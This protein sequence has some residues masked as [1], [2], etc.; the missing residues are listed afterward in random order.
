MASGMISARPQLSAVTCVD[1]ADSV[2]DVSHGEC[3]ASHLKWRRAHAD[4]EPKRRYGARRPAEPEAEG[5]AL[6][7][8]ADRRM[9]GIIPRP[10][11]GSPASRRTD[12]IRDHRCRG[13]QVHRYASVGLPRTTYGA[14]GVRLQDDVV[15]DGGLDV[16]RARSI[17]AVAFNRKAPVDISDVLPGI[18]DGIG[19]QNARAVRAV[20]KIG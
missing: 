9:I 20:F 17:S 4:A 13:R 2:D 11:G 1:S 14:R 7:T 18:E 3:S 16:T 15:L 19:V 10:A 12:S 5:K 6:A 8:N